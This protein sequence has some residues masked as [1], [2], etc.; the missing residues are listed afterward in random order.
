MLAGDNLA[1]P[2]GLRALWIAGPIEVPLWE[3][4]AGAMVEMR[5]T[6][7]EVSAGPEMVP[8]ANSPSVQR[9][10]L[11]RRGFQDSNLPM[12]QAPSAGAVGGPICDEPTRASNTLFRVDCQRFVRS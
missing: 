2:L 8:G 9:P 1:I 5:T 3:A 12:A 11:A 10:T 7:Q 6:R 4:S